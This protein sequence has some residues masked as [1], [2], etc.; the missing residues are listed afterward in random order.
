M[1][2]S[3]A[4]TIL[5]Y[6]FLYPICGYNKLDDFYVGTSI[7]ENHNKHLDLGI[8]F[9]YALFFFLCLP[10][11]H[12][13]KS[14]WKI[15]FKPEKIL[16]PINTFFNKF[17]LN[18]EKLQTS[19]LLIFV[20]FSIYSTLQFFM[21][22]KV[23]NI[24]CLF[25][26]IIFFVCF[27]FCNIK[28][29][30]HFYFITQIL[31]SLNYIIMC[32]LG[33]KYPY[34]LM[35]GGF[36]ILINIIY[37]YRQIYI[38]N[39]IK[40]S[41]LTIIPLILYF[42]GAGYNYGLLSVDDFH[43]GEELS[44]FYIHENFKTNFYKDI[45]L[46]HGILD[47]VPAWLGKYVFGDAT[48]YGFFLGKTLFANLILLTNSFLAFCVFRKK[49]VFALGFLLMLP[50]FSPYDFVYTII[51]SYLILLEKINR[52]KPIFWLYIYTI[53]AFFLANFS[54]TIGSAWA[55]ASL[56]LAIYAFYKLVKSELNGKAKFIQIF[57]LLLLNFIICFFLKD[58]YLEYWQKASFYVHG[59]LYAFGNN[60][61]AKF[62]VHEIF[63]SSLKLFSLLIVP[64]LF[65]ELLKSDKKNIK[66][67][68]A[69][70]FAILFSLLL[71]NYTLG[72]I[73][74]IIFKRIRSISFAYVVI[75]I[76]YLF[77]VLK[78]K[79]I[80]YVGILIIFAVLITSAPHFLFNSK[81]ST[82]HLDANYLKNLNSI[83]TAVD[84]Y[85]KN[86]SDFLDLTNHGINYKY[87]NKKSPLP[88]LSFYTIIT[89][90]QSQEALKILI[91]NEPK[92]ILI[93]PQ[94]KGLDEIYPSIRINAI[95]RW[96]LLSEKYSVLNDNENT[97]LIKT[98]F[99]KYSQS[100]L[101]QL[102]KI[103]SRNDIKRLPEAWGNSINNLSI[104]KLDVDKNIKISQNSVS[105][106]LKNRLKGKDIKF[107]YIETEPNFAH[108]ITQ[109]EV[110]VNN[111]NSILKFNASGKNLL[112]PFDNFPSWLLN[113]NIKQIKISADKKKIL[114]KIEIFVLK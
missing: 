7:Y 65:V 23:F 18:Q 15:D 93:S 83:K 26:M 95:Y 58:F 19:F 12:Y 40:I 84:K 96:I 61:P 6:K 102:D 86:S 77:Y 98:H 101:Q 107:V 32:P 112:I 91:Q 38:K 34:L 8:F 33:G 94:V 108:N 73:D 105:I 82:P 41:L 29:N 87:L 53:G 55:V 48:I 4:I 97:F 25:A 27:Y 90:K 59:S 39:E 1:I 66:Y 72:R 56:P 81:Y 51:L 54:T 3:A 79:F 106:N 100:E 60:F 111:S 68:F 21:G 44:T 37:L 47:M 71:I 89:T 57:S 36:F 62:N 103:F 30:K 13:I 43:H 22:I 24:F 64:C 88:Y 67:V 49:P 110:S 114:K 78:P 85:S 5:I 16:S 63:S 92:I 69:L 104:K 35:L 11:A 17:S 99:H 76:P 46:V 9:I 10:I 52:I 31:I 70:V 80:K 45:M 14:L 2:I 50:C 28:A 75:L 113:D 20:I 109:Y 74:Y 42:W